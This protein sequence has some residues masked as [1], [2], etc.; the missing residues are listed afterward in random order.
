MP[1]AVSKLSCRKS[2]VSGLVFKDSF[3][4]GECW[5]I[6]YLLIS[7]R[8]LYKDRYVLQLFCVDTIGF[9]DRDDILGYSWFSDWDKRLLKLG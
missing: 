4:L 6:C 9:I 8:H 3:V 2:L 1:I 5:A 7:T